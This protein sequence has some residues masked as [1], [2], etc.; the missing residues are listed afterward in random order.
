MIKES[1]RTIALIGLE[2][3]TDETDFTMA[4][5]ILSSSVTILPKASL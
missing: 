2:G 1:L 4:A 5:S 3:V